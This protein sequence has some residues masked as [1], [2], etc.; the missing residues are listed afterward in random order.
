M[1]QEPL[2]ELRRRMLDHQPR[3]QLYERLMGYDVHI[4]DGPNFYILYKDIFC[5][6]IYHFDSPRP[7]PLI[8]DCGSNIGLSVL[9]FKHLYPSS[10]IVAFEPDPTILPYLEENLQRNNLSDVRIVRAALATREGSQWLHCDGK[11]GSTLQEYGSNGCD[12]EARDDTDDSRVT[13]VRLADYLT[14]PV[15]FLKMNI[16]GAEADV[17]ADSEPQLR[18]VRAM[19]IEY[20]HLPGLPRTL[21][22]ILALLDRQGF[23]YLIHSFDRETNP[24]GQPPFHLGPQSRCFLL[25]YAQRKD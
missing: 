5:R 3:S 18:Q 8:L 13:C 15:E 23:E 12:G 6:K 22:H 11:Y 24:Q 16:E 4:N 20:H 10:R 14:Q 17:L 21:H 1:K 9:Y 25:I 19:V 7:D 2:D